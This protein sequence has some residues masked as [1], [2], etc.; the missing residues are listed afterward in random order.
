MGTGQSQ[1]AKQHTQ[2]YTGFWKNRLSVRREESGVY[3]EK[4]TCSVS[5][6]A[7]GPRMRVWGVRAEVWVSDGR[8]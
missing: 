5:K 3:L 4:G 1:D 2:V 7:G 8:L 6:R